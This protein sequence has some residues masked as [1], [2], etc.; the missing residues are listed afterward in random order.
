MPAQSALMSFLLYGIRLLFF[1]PSFFFLHSATAQ[2]A[3]SV[4]AVVNRFLPEFKYKQ[5]LKNCV[6]LRGGN[7]VAGRRNGADSISLGA[8]V[9]KVVQ[10][11]L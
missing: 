3:D 1:V 6:F 11:F 9:N 8:P 10:P 7:F 5:E 4:I 2:N